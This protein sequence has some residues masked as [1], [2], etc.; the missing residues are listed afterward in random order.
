M[1]DKEKYKILCSSEDSIPIFSKDWWLDCVCGKDN[2]DVI[3][4]EKN[5]IIAASFPLYFYYPN[6]IFM[7]AFTQTM[8][9]WFNPGLTNPDYSAE[10]LRKQQICNEFIPIL[11]K[12]KIFSQN[13][14]HTF[15]DWLP[16]YWAGYKQT[17]RYTY[18]LQDISN[19]ESIQNNFCTNINRN[20]AK[21]Q[22]KYKLEIRKTI[23]ISEFIEVNS[24]TFKRQG[25][26]AKNQQILERL[27]HIC[28]SR[29]QGDTW[30][31]YDEQ[32]RLHAAVFIAWQET[33][34]YYIAGGGNP[35]L[36]NSGAHAFAM[37]EGIKH[38]STFSKSFDFEG[39][40]IQGV[41]RFFREFGAIQ[42]PYFTIS[43]GNLSFIKKVFLHSQK[44]AK[45]FFEK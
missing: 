16:F 38:T 11:S 1:T 29:N 12:Y 41:E 14:C 31:A 28:R 13:F 30:G 18:I 7:P 24:L 22:N 43:K 25:E 23:P 3:L 10:L 2:W 8:G 42:T 21:A 9:I 27:I 17:T 37:W 33:C 26:K 15:T 40:M 35:D 36:R 45:R 6:I 4:I 39:S 19:I 20:I 5:G 34:A 44:Q 32:G